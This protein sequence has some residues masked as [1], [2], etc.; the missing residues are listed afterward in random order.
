MTDGTCGAGQYSVDHALTRIIAEDVANAGIEVVGWSW[1]QPG[2]VLLDGPAARTGAL[3]PDRTQ[4]PRKWEEVP[5]AA[6][7]PTDRLK[8]MDAAGV[9]Y[10][11]LY[12]SVAGMARQ[13]FGRLEDPALE[14]A[15]AQAY[16]D[17]LLEEWACASERFIPLCIV[18]LWPVAETVAQIRRAVG[19]G[20]RGVVFRP[21]R[22]KLAAQ[23]VFINQANEQI[24]TQL[25][26]GE[27]AFMISQTPDAVVQVKAKDPKAPVKYVKAAEGV[28]V[29][30][31]SAGVLKSAPH[32]NAAR[33]WV[34]WRLS[35]EGQEAMAQQGNVPVGKSVKT[36]YYET[37]LEGVKLLPVETQADRDKRAEYS[38]QWDDIFF[39]R[40]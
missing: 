27:Y 1:V 13:A 8:A 31:T 40:G 26:R 37:S 7:V 34:H 32:P 17:W 21:C 3:M 39:K 5:P 29:S 18:P 10:S 33:L 38:K 2:H 6:Y 4:E 24:F 28:A 12:P 30:D 25:M 20:H 23:D 9:D 19:M 16:N 35:Q 22:R 11:V 15:C 14:L 36:P